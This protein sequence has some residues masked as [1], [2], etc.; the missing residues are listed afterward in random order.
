M[1][2]FKFGGP[3][4]AHGDVDGDGVEDALRV[5]PD[6]EIPMRSSKRGEEW[7]IDKDNPYIASAGLD[8]VDGDG[9]LDVWY[10][11]GGPDEI[12]IWYGD[13]AGYFPAR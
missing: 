10:F 4:E 7:R 13:G 8:D 12:W 2:S 6:G 11:D 9:C 5:L 3:T 1:P